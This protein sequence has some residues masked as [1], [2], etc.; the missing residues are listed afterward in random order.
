MGLAGLGN[1]GN[2][3]FMNSSLQCLSHAPPLVSLAPGHALTAQWKL[4][5]CNIP[6]TYGRDL[7]SFY[8]Q[9]RS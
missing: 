5:T 6:V 8:V 3:C 4:Y 2:T 7:L 9:W 1:L